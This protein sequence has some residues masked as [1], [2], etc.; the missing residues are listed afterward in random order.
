MAAENP[1]KPDSTDWGWGR[2]Q[3]HRLPTSRPYGF[4]VAQS[5]NLER[6]IDDP[7]SQLFVLGF[8]LLEG[9]QA[10]GWPIDAG[11]GND[12]SAGQLMFGITTVY[13][14]QLCPPSLA[15]ATS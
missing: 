13:E 4:A 7:C 9:W 5:L 8:E 10:K 2:R 15:R 1:G 11:P 14:T 12:P 6:E 3:L